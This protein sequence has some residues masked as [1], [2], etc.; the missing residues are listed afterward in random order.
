[1]TAITPIPATTTADPPRDPAGDR[2]R[3]AHW[4]SPAFPTGGFAWSQGLETA[5]AA[6]AVRDAATLGAWVSAVLLHGGARTDAILL[7]HAR[8]AGAD[9]GALDAL[10]RALAPS[11]ERLAE[12]LEQ[13]A[14]FAATVAAVTGT[15]QPALPYP[16]AVGHA[17]RPLALA[18]AEV[19]AHYLQAQAMQLAAAG[20]RFIPL[21]QSDGH[22]VIAAAAALIPSLA[23]ACAA[24]T[25]D[26]IG[27]ATFGA[28]IAAMAHETLDVRIFRS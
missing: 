1:M 12:T 26:D 20:M 11:A 8:A 19:V 14:A 2:L 4:L 7:A 21:S 5:M 15:P 13:G 17:T 23:E 25:L 27:T 28:D 24:A 9:T 3:L 22:R 6:G 18:T 16:L 10:A